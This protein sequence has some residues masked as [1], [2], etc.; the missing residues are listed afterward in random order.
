MKELLDVAL[1]YG[2]NPKLVKGL[3]QDRSEY[4]K[5]LLNSALPHV[6]LLK[7]EDG[8]SID[9]ASLKFVLDELK[10]LG[11]QKDYAL[12]QTLKGMFMSENRNSPKKLLL[13]KY[14]GNQLFIGKAYAEF[15]QKAAGKRNFIDPSVKIYTASHGFKFISKMQEGDHDDFFPIASNLYL[16]ERNGNKEVWKEN[17]K[18]YVDFSRLDGYTQEKEIYAAVEHKNIIK[19]LGL[20]N[21]DGIDF[22][23][24]EFFPGKQLSEYTKKDSLLPVDESVKIIKTLAEVLDYLHEKGILYMDIK[25]KNVMYDGKEVKLLDFGMARYL[26]KPIDDQTCVRSL[27]STPAY[28][29]PECGTSFKVYKQTDTFM[30]GVLFYQLLTGKHPFANYDFSEGDDKRESEII[31]YSLSNIFNDYNPK[32]LENYPIL[33]DLIGRMLDKDPKKRPLPKEIADCLGNEF[34]SK[35]YE[36]IILSI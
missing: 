26:D 33:N 20:T 24:F 32:D 23:R 18:L 9:E 35:D 25:D 10:H 36:N 4:R 28:V 19:C 6:M 5:F 31:K 30:L 22:M 8:F 34:V 17:L 13:A 27:L 1:W 3:C 7:D 11:V 15:K 2:R 29:A 16:I 12:Q 14:S 21:I